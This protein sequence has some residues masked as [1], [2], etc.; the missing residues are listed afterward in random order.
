M[1]RERLGAERDARRPREY[2]PINGGKP[3]RRPGPVLATKDDVARAQRL[4]YYQSVVSAHQFS[5]SLAETTPA[6]RELQSI[7]GYKKSGKV[8]PNHKNPQVVQVPAKWD[9]R[10]QGVPP[11]KDQGQCGSCWAFGSTAVV[12]SAIGIF[13]KTAVNLSEQYVIDCNNDQYDCNGGDGAY[14]MY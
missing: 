3:E 12:E 5:Y 2:P 10:G 6:H 4:S 8:N 13:A 9:W 14:D 11:I 7:T 1:L